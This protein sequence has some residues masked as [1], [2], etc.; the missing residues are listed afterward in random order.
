MC[1]ICLVLLV[2]LPSSDRGSERL[3][4]RVEEKTSESVQHDEGIDPIQTITTSVLHDDSTA[5]TLYLFG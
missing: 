3:E 5:G 1:F 4:S 2:E